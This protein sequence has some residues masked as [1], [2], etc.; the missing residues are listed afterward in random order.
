MYKQGL[1]QGNAFTNVRN[2][3]ESKAAKEGDSPQVTIRDLHFRNHELH[4]L[5]NLIPRSKRLLDIGCGNGFG[6]FILSQRADYTLGV[7]YAESMI[8]RAS[9]ARNNCMDILR[10]DMKPTPLISMETESS[11]RT[12]FAV[13][14]ILD[15]NLDINE[16]DVITGQRILIN[17]PSHDQQ[18]KALEHLRRY[19]L[20]NS[21]LILTEA[22]LQG[23][24]RTDEYRHRFG[25]PILEKHWNNV[26][27]DESHFDEWTNHGWQVV[28]TLSFETYMLLSKVIYPAAVGT[29]N[30][31]FLSGANEAACE[32]ANLFRTKAAAKEI[33]I[34]SMLGMYFE[35][36]K[37]YNEI[38]GKSIKKWIGDHLKDLPD[39]KN[40]GHQKIIVAKAI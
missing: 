31:I 23:H 39:W 24:Q 6:T 15:L 9:Q 40:L 21:L 30:C 29:E 3:W 1:T 32:I 34:D 5:L 11:H 2:F 36:V 26:Y 14:D 22:T 13:G 27:V 12:D 35:R 38:D 16:F 19:S 25:L 4:T 18:M 8:L 17:L 37:R 33:C 20:I 10:R 7:D 28:N